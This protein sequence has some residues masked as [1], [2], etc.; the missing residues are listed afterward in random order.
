[1]L[2]V[3]LSICSHLF[4]SPF[5]RFFGNIISANTLGLK[6]LHISSGA[7]GTS[8]ADILNATIDLHL[9]KLECQAGVSVATAWVD[10]R[11]SSFSF[12]HL[13]R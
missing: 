2:W 10:I 1:M 8:Y 11:G 12:P 4:L 9:G 13:I 6:R 5:S 3:S 7:D